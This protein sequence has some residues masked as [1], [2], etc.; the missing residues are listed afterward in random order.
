MHGTIVQMHFPLSELLSVILG[1]RL[2]YPILDPIASIVIC[3]MI[4][5]ASIDIF[6]DAIDKMVDHSCDAKN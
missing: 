4:A 2:G 3:V 1:A 6:R 5:K